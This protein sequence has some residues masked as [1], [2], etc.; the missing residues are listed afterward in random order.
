ML[1]LN[2]FPQGPEGPDLLRERRSNPHSG[3]EDGIRSMIYL[4]FAGQFGIQGGHT[5]G[6][7]PSVVANLGRPSEVIVESVPFPSEPRMGLL[8]SRRLTRSTHTHNLSRMG[9]ENFGNSSNNQGIEPMAGHLHG[10]I[11]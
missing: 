9:R 4:D 3:T 10:S 5:I 1:K 11:A 2:R 8:Q 6:T 7:V